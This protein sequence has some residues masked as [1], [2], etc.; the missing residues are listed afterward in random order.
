M[1][2]WIA[3]YPKS[4]NTWIRSLLSAYLFSKKGDFNFSLLKNIEQF[5]SS[6]FKSQ[7]GE[8]IHYQARISKNWIPAQKIINNDNKIHILK[9][10]NAIC[11]IS[12]NY[13]T[14]KFNTIGA[15]YIVRDPRNLVTSLS[16]HYSMK[17]DDSYKFLTNKRKIIFP[18]NKDILNPE[19]DPK[20]FNFLSDWA[21]HYKS[22]KN[23]NFCSVKIIRYED[24]MVNTKE[25]FISILKYLS[26]FIDIKIDENKIDNAINSTKF[27]Q[28]SEME[29]KLGFDESV[30]SSKTNKKVKF[31]HLGKKNDWKILLDKSVKNKIETSFQ[32]EMK[33]L[34][35]F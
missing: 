6:D 23:I 8:N 2:I 17:L 14:D 15:I 25:I 7:N 24:F 21:T 12:G 5:S 26:S 4:G 31:F 10:H 28:M 9:T 30:T 35:Y 19:K 13:F 29:D 11:S 33:E 34:K 3:S 27:D 16:H 1:I 18:L 20:D 32:N 22:W